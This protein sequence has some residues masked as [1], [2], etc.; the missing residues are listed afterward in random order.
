MRK[1]TLSVESQEK[2]EIIKKLAEG[3]ISK[4][5]AAV[6][7]GCTQRHINRL[8]KQYQLLGKTSFVHRNTGRKLVHA[9]SPQ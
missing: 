3:H 9:R 8:L 5:T 6:K 1:V 7:I 4:Q 2:Y